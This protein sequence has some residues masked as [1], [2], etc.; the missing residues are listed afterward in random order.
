MGVKLVKQFIAYSVDVP[1]NINEYRLLLNMA[2][3][4]LDAD[5]PPRYFDSRE[6]SAYALGRRIPDPPPPGEPEL[7]ERLAAFEAVKTA[8]RGLV[9]L[10]AIERLKTGHRGQRAEYAIR[11]DPMLSR[12]TDEWRKRKARPSPKPRRNRSADPTD[13]PSVD[14]TDDPQPET[15]RGRLALP[16]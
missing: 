16:V 9:G 12:G 14:P 1:L 7:P 3:T 5:N 2:L 13:D 6:A 11:L 15:E 8:T 10:R 4:A